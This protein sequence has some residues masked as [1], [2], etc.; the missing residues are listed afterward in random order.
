M[1]ATIKNLIPEPRQAD[2]QPRAYVG[3]HRQPEKFTARAQ[4]TVVPGPGGRDPD[5]DSAA[6]EGDAPADA[7]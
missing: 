3:R 4:V 6:A 5:K 2:Q 1:F 7:A